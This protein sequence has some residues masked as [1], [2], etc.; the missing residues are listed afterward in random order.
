MA[1]SLS[2]PGITKRLGNSV[3]II[4]HAGN[5]AGVPSEMLETYLRKMRAPLT[6]VRKCQDI[7]GLIAYKANMGWCREVDI[8]PRMD[9]RLLSYLLAIGFLGCRIVPGKF[10]EPGHIIRMANTVKANPDKRH[11]D[12]MD[13]SG[14]PV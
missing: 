6:G 4:F 11:A 12:V 3:M 5:D 14:A 13:Y 2:W 7:G 8:S 10:W 9:L 1:T